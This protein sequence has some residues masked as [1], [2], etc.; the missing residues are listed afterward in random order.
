MPVLPDTD[1]AP[2][3]TSDKALL[4]NIPAE[5]AVT[6]LSVDEPLFKVDAV[7]VP[8]TVSLPLNRVLPVTLKLPPILVFPLSV[9]SP[10]I[11][12]A[13]VVRTPLAVADASGNIKGMSRTG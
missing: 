8:V 1:Q 10:A 3:N 5:F 6:I 9:L 13:P 12:C 11:V 4:F 2:F 7:I